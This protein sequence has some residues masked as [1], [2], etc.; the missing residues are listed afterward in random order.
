M[1]KLDRYYMEEEEPPGLTDSATMRKASTNL[2]GVH[3]GGCDANHVHLGVVS[4]LLGA[5]GLAGLL[6]LALDGLRHGN[7]LLH[8]PQLLQS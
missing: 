8:L 6:G 5:Q 3:G 2:L 7:V 1:L 4:H